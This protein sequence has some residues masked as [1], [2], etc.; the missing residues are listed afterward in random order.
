VE[1]GLDLWA[2]TATSALHLAYIT[3]VMD[4]ISTRFQPRARAPNYLDREQNG[5]SEDSGN[6]C[7]LTALPSNDSHL[8]PSADTN[9]AESLN[10]RKFQRTAAA[11]TDAADETF[12]KPTLPASATRTSTD[13]RPQLHHRRRSTLRDIPRVPSGP[14]EFPSP[15]RRFEQT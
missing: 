11:R 12:R 14:R 3:L 5:V 4:V 8:S 7:E 13:Q 15:S 2:G 6:D 9:A 1:H 10:R